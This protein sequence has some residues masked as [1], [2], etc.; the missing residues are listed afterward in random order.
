MEGE[1]GTIGEKQGIERKYFKDKFYAKLIRLLIK[2]RTII[3][4]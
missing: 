3:I 4:K 2:F 1:T